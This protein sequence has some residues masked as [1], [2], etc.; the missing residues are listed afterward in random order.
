[1][2]DGQKKKYLSIKIFLVIYLRDPIDFFCHLSYPLRFFY[3]SLTSK[4]LM[5]LGT[6]NVMLECLYV[7]A[8]SLCMLCTLLQVSE[9]Q[10]SK[11]QSGLSGAGF[12]TFSLARCGFIGV[13]APSRNSQKC[14]AILHNQIILFSIPTQYIKFN[15]P[16]S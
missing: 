5:D 14:N 9:I 2:F 8:C 7:T 3:I 16:F 15:Y 13:S 12:S 10:I 11:S 6:Y 1:M 4:G